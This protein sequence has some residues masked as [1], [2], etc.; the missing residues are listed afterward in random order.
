MKAKMVVI[1]IVAS[2]FFIFAIILSCPVVAFP[3]SLIINILLLDQ[4]FRAML[5]LACFVIAGTALICL[6]NYCEKEAE[7]KSYMAKGGESGK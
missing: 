3:P 6:W 2:L 7:K 1:L 4:A 5:A